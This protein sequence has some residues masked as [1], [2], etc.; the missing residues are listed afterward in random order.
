MRYW[1]FVALMMIVTAGWAQEPAEDLPVEDEAAAELQ[2]GEGSAPSGAIYVPIK[3]PFVVNYGGS[4]RLKY[5]KAEVTLRVEDS[6]TAASVRHHLPYIRNDLV[7]L[8]GSQTEEG[9]SSQEGKEALRL[10][11]LQAVRDLL[12]REER[13]K[14]I[15]DLYFTS[16][17]VQK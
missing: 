7:M 1:L 4:G 5:I 15:V 11:A 6:E 8:F 9:I 10:E 14:G 12:H 2:G 17:L 13:R 16:L 3:P